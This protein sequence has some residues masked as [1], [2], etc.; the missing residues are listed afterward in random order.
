IGSATQQNSPPGQPHPSKPTRVQGSDPFDGDAP[1][2]R[3]TNETNSS[4]LAI[5]PAIAP[6]SSPIG[7]AIPV[8]KFVKTFAD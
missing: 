4:L 8:A 3:P 2:I 1:P 7:T 5:L 6:S